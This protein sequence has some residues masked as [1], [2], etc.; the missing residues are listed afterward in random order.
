MEAEDIA[1]ALSYAWLRR[2]MTPVRAD[3]VAPGFVSSV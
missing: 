1:E 3:A 2:V